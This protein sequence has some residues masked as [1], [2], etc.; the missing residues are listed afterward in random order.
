MLFKID[1]YFEV[2]V[3]FNKIHRSIRN[4]SRSSTGRVV[5]VLG[6]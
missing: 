4:S 6:Y 3:N 5:V 1:I 2:T